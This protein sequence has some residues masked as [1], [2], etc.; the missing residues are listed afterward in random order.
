MTEWDTELTPNFTRDEMKCSCGCGRSDMDGDFMI[1]LQAIRDSFG[2][3]RVTSAFRCEN[4]PVEAVKERPGT[5]GQGRAVDVAVVGGARMALIRVAMGNGMR[6][7]GFGKT[8]QHLD[9]RDKYQ[10]WTY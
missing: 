2:P 8:F 3:L 7:F 9:D 6:G 1:K 10:S 4:H 5:H